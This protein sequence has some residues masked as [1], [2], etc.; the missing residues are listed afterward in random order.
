MEAD[1]LRPMKKN[2]AKKVLEGGIVPFFGDHGYE[3]SG[4]WEHKAFHGDMTPGKEY[5][6]VKKYYPEFDKNNIYFWVI[7][8]EGD[9][10]RIHRRFFGVKR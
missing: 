10:K 5:E 8:D 7:N 1:K 6:V 2:E 3:G 9:K 4:C